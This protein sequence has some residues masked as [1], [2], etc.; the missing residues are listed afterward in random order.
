MG[1]GSMKLF[2][3]LI[4]NYAV[5]SSFKQKKNQCRLADKIKKKGEG[6]TFHFLQPDCVM[7]FKSVSVK[8]AKTSQF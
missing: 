1:V 2:M 4:D 5:A 8:L 3:L 7:L 6:I